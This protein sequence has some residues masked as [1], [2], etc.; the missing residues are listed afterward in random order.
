MKCNTDKNRAYAD[1]KRYKSINQLIK[2]AYGLSG[3]Q[4]RKQMEWAEQQVQSDML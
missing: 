3:E 1:G 4:I 2:D